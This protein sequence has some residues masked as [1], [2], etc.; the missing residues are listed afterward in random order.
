VQV[1]IATELPSFAA[2][3]RITALGR[4]DAYVVPQ[5]GGFVLD[6]EKMRPVIL[7]R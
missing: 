3:H 4:H 7:P 6:A 2:E 5:G 1:R